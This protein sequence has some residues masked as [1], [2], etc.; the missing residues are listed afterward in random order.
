[1][2]ASNN[3]SAL[4]KTS[5]GNTSRFNSKDSE[6]ATRTQ[7]LN[8]ERSKKTIAFKNKKGFVKAK[9]KSRKGAFLSKNVKVYTPDELL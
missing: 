1:M 5:Q 3:L 6:F 7:Q 8:A 2:A 9:S 4:D